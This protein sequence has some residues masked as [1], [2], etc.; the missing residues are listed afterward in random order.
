MSNFRLIRANDESQVEILASMHH[1]RWEVFSKELKW[2]VGLQTFNCMEHDIY[3][4][5][6][7]V[8]I[9]RVNDELKVDACCRLM[10]TSRPYMLG[11]HYSHF[12]MH[13]PIPNS[14]RIWEISRT[15]ASQ[16]A[17]RGSTS[18]TA[19]L[20][21]ASIEFGLTNKIES[22]ISLTSTRLYPILKR[23]VGWDSCCLGNAM[24][25]NFE[26][27]NESYALK[28]PV[29]YEALK[30]IRNKNHF[31][32]PFLFDVDRDLLNVTS[33]YCVDF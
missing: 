12:I 33:V 7:S 13:E 18:I 28:H 16:E 14:D 26:D 27:N 24:I 25:T 4:K 30:I 10:P 23:V 8:Y 21:A 11:E 2:T 29:S 6:G 1:L 19:Q 15:C 5:D 31:S 22:F 3:D 9:V 17:R 32:E 20:I